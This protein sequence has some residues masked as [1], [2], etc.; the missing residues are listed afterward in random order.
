MTWT[1]DEVATSVVHYG[2]CV[3]Q[4]GPHG[5]RRELVTAH[6]VPLIGAGADSDLLLPGR[7][8]GRLRQC[9]DL[10]RAARDPLSFVTPATPCPA[11]CNVA[12]FALGRLTR[13][14]RSRS[15]VTVRCILKPSRRK[16]SR[17]TSSATGSAFG[18]WAGG[19]SASWSAARGDGDGASHLLP[20]ELRT[21]LASNSWPPTGRPPTSTSDSRAMGRSAPPWVVIGMGGATDG[22]YARTY[23]GTETRLTTTTLGTPHRYRIDWRSGASSSTWTVSR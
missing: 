21:G 9:R 20:G 12:D 13:T 11:D 22:V 23:A 5:E 8:G 4:L 17:A 7:V 3:E 18:P 6:S 1:T 16:S 15:R 19:G 2:L 10:A 14:R